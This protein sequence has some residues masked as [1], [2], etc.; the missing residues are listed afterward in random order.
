MSEIQNVFAEVFICPE[1]MEL[2][3]ES[4]RETHFGATATRFE[5]ASRF[6]AKPFKS[7]LGTEQFRK[8]SRNPSKA[9]WKLNNSGSC[10]ETLQKP[11]ET[12]RFRKLFATKRSTLEPFKS[13]L[14][15]EQFRKLS[16]NPWKANGNGTIPEA[17]R[18]EAFYARSE[19]A[20]KLLWI[21]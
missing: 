1:T 17:V 10:R 7:Q 3:Q 9:N 15:T 2:L 13:Q 4:L 18:Y 8:L 6:D 11:T 19:G 21:V 14:E 16:R 12:E 20:A 5:L